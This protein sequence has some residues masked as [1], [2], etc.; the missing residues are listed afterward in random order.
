MLAKLRAQVVEECRQ[1]QHDEKWAERHQKKM[2]LFDFIR[3]AFVLSFSFSLVCV[4]WVFTSA[5][6]A[7][8]CVC[9][10]DSGVYLISK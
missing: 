10:Q 2:V 9:G 8:M 5:M 1:Y 6:H 7:C 3:R 4:I